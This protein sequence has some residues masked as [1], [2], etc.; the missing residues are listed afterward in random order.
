[1][2]PASQHLAYDRRGWETSRRLNGRAGS[3]WHWETQEDKQE[4][5]PWSRR[6]T[7]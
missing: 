1:M 5:R 2:T 7:I 3:I 4:T 6:H